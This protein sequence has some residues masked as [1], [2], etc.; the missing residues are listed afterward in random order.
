MAHQTKAKG[1]R[2]PQAYWEQLET[3][4]ANEKKSVNTVVAQWIAV[5]LSQIA[6]SKPEQVGA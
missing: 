2:L 5:N 4:A 1:I 3:I 6:S